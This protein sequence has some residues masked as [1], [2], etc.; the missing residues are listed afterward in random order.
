MFN[1]RCSNDDF[2]SDIIDVTPVKQRRKEVP[3]VVNNFSNFFKSIGE[4]FKRTSQHN[5]RLF[6]VLP[7]SNSA[8][9]AIA[10]GGQ[11]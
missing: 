1:F 8:E 9:A 7:E 2:D 11:V 10:H 3:S 5:T 6:G 4:W